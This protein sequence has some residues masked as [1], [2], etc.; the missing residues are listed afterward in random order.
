M[1]WAS[2]NVKGWIGRGE[3]K[4]RETAEAQ[5]H[6]VHGLPPPSTTPEPLVKK[7]RT[8]KVQRGVP[9]FSAPSQG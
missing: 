2:K 6:K 1:G 4:S 3:G 5:E 9:E 8:S 7:K